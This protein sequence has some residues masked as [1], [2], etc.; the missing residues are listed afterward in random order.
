M[1]NEATISAQLM[2]ADGEGTSDSMTVDAIAA[3]VA[4]KVFSRTKQSVLTS[5]TA[6]KLGSISTAGWI[7]V[8]NRDVS[9]YVDIKTSASGIIFARLLAGELILLRLGTGAQ[10]PVAV[11]NTATCQVEVL[12]LSS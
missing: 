11:A 8:V 6:L 9:N 1:A 2:Y 12:V 5:E 3:D 7:M 10:A 4:I